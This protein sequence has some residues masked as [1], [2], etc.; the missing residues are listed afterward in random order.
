MGKLL[1]F[2]REV[3]LRGLAMAEFKGKYLIEV[4]A[5]AWGSLGLA[6]MA[7]VDFPRLLVEAALG[8]KPRPQLGYRLG[9]RA[10]WLK[11][12]L[13]RLRLVPF[14]AL[15]FLRGPWRLFNGRLSDPGPAIRE[16]LRV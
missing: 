2:Y 11:G 12:D 6:L 16:V 3:G 5:R 14:E 8:L 7:G 10:R 15:E 9:L 1:K 4:N 13:A